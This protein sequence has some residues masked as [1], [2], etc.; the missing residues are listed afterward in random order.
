MSEKGLYEQILGQQIDQG[1]YQQQSQLN[2]QMGTGFGVLGRAIGQWGSP[3]IQQYKPIRPG[4]S[5]QS[6]LQSQK[7][8]GKASDRLAYK[9]FR[10][11]EQAEIA[12]KDFKDKRFREPLDELRIEVAQ[13]LNN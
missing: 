11:N 8:N 1:A 4:D 3:T 2:Q 10:I 9:F 5:Y 7:F 13:W 6:L 12:D